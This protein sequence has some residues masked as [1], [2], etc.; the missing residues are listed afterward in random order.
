MKN[1]ILRS[2]GC[3]DF[4]K[5]ARNDGFK[6]ILFRILKMKKKNRQKKSPIRKY[7]VHILRTLDQHGT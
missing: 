3:D 7:L 5:S 2:T 4:K 1:K 6:N